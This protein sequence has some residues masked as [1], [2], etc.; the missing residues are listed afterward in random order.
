MG[1]S[2][3]FVRGAVLLFP[4]VFLFPQILLFPQA[5]YGQTQPAT[6]DVTRQ[7]AE[8]T[9]LVQKLQSRVEELETKLITR[10]EPPIE[11]SVE[12]PTPVGPRDAQSAAK[13]APRDAGLQAGAREAALP[14]AE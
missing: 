7:I 13:E 14:A 2:S 6:G 8:L 5:V 4:P 12:Q 1:R 9:A 10:S 3:R 11:R